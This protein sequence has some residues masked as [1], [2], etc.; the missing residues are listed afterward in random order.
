MTTDNTEARCVLCEHAKRQIDCTHL[1]YRCYEPKEGSPNEPCNC[2]CIFGLREALKEIE[3]VA[4][5]TANI[6]KSSDEILNI[7][8]A[9]LAADTQPTSAVSGNSDDPPASS[10]L[11]ESISA[12][13]CGFASDG[14]PA[15]WPKEGYASESLSSS[16][17]DTTG[18]SKTRTEIIREQQRSGGG[19]I[20]AVMVSPEELPER[21]WLN[22]ITL[23]RGSGNIY[24]CPQLVDQDDI[25]F[26]RVH[27]R[28][29]GGEGAAKRAA[30]E[31][32]ADNSGLPCYASRIHG[33]MP[34]ARNTSP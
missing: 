20:T 30:Q 17:P 21:I 29:K 25:E 31:L 10:V 34:P 12:E 7:A 32:A 9:A 15:N 19:E 16:S 24:K 33:A 27:P 22:P 8:R 1:V 28:S 3:T 4:M 11:H 18:E 23:R 2:R 26:A 5:R 6:W 13:A 14:L